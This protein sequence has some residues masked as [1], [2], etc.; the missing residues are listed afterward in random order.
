MSIAEV[1]QIF[2]LPFM[3]RAL[4]GLVV[5]AVAA[6]IVGL[7]VNLRDLE[8]ISD[9][10]THAVFP[11]LVV[12]YLVGG[13]SWILAGALGAALVGAVILTLVDRRRVG[14]DAGIAVVLASM[15]SIGVVLISRSDGYVAELEQLLFGRLLT[16]TDVQ[17]RQIV[18][19]AVLAVVV[20]GATARLQLFRAFDL[21]GYRAAGLRDLQVDIALNIAV[22]LIVVAGSQAIG[23]LMVLALLILPVGTARLVTRKLVGIVPIAVVVAVVTAVVGLVAGFELSVSHGLALSPSAVVVLVMIAVYLVVLLTSQTWLWAARRGA[24]RRADSRAQN[25]TI[26]GVPGR[27]VQGAP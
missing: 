8:F 26:G 27:T 6:A 1:A 19:V 7:F 21:R 15:F 17:L 14:S 25:Q 20:V 24:R 4:I 9:G 11:G 18:I 5:L 10:L 3:S 23:N 13:T 12:G 2:E 22:A 16:M